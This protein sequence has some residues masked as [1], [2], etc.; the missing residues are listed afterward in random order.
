MSSTLDEQIAAFYDTK[1]KRLELPLIVSQAFGQLGPDFLV[2][3]E[4]EHALQDQTFGLAHYRQSTEDAALAANALI[5]G[6]AMLAAV[7]LL[8]F[9][10]KQP[11]EKV[12]TRMIKLLPVHA[13]RSAGEA[14]R[15][16]Q[17]APRRAGDR[18]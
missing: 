13:R 17:R 12:L 5:E 9:E 6:D 7:E 2:S 11:T 18:A 3:H 10:N 15:P 1:K 16:L 8:A 14:L 4:I